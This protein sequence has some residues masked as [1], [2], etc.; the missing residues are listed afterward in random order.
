[1]LVKILTFIVR[2]II[3]LVLNMFL[4]VGQFPVPVITHILSSVQVFIQCYISNIT[5]FLK[6]HCC[7]VMVLVMLKGI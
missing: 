3:C 5:D 1:M 2:I 6:L 7:H 4:S